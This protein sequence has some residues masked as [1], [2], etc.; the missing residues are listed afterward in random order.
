MKKLV[1]IWLICLLVFPVHGQTLK[2][3]ARLQEVFVV[4]KRQVSERALSVKSID[5]VVLI[6]AVTADLSDLLLKN[7]SIYIKSYG[8]GGLATASFRGTS[9]SHTQVLWNGLNINSPLWGQTDLSLLPIFFTDDVSLFYGSSSLMKTSGGFGGCI[10]L[11]NTPTWNN[12]TNV[13]LN[14]TAG[15]F[16]YFLSQAKAGFSGKKFVSNTRIFYEEAKNDF[17]YRDDA[18]GISGYPRQKNAEFDKEGFLQEFYFKLNSHQFAG[19]KIMSLWSDRNLPQ[20]MSFLGSN[21]YENQKDN[22]LNILGEWKYYGS[23]SSFSFSSG[24]IGNNLRYVLTN[25]NPEGTFVNYNTESDSRSFANKLNFQYNFTDNTILKSSLDYIYTDARYS[26]L[27][28]QSRFDVERNDLMLQ[29]S[30]HHVFSTA[31][32][33]YALA[34]QK[35]LDGEFMPFIAAVGIEYDLS[36][37]R[38]LVVMSNLGRN[39]HVPNLNDMYFVPGGNRDLK[40][41]TGYQADAALQWN[42]KSESTQYQLEL[43]GFTAW[44]DNWILWRP[45]EYRYWV[46]DNVQ[47]VFSRGVEVNANV[48]GE[49]AWFRYQL[50]GGYGYTRTTDKEENSPSYGQQLIYIP[51]HI[52]NLQVFLEKENY[53][54]FVSWHNTGAR[55]SSTVEDAAHRVTPYFLVDMGL[56]KLWHLK[57]HTLNLNFRLNNVLN[58]Q[59]QVIQYRAMPGRNFSVSVRFNFSS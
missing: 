4:S 31:L 45:S 30:V 50:K 16:G 13:S 44:V 19:V 12:G 35:L 52:G 58:K 21:R 24:L 2:D 22:L 20:I 26:D 33:G 7:S 5:S 14:Q 40:P 6:N 18:S 15:S 28:E 8:V 10:T 1:F 37:N 9:A 39:L 17:K 55:Y 43:A 25:S 3:T 47:Q 41:E 42:K 36:A 56:G 32:S 38:Q 34:Q 54:A 46:A 51:R 49:F 57:K 11:S 23:K 59:Y 53:S 48:N 29:S 27:K